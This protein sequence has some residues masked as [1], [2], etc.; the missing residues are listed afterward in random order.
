[1][2]R[3]L[4]LLFTLCIAASVNAQSDD[5]EIKT[6]INSFFDGMRKGDS[7][8]VRKAFIADPFLMTS[9]M[10]KGE[11]HFE[12]EKLSQLLKAVSTPRKPGEVYDERLLSMEI[13]VDDRLASVWTP[14]A[15]YV[16]ETF[17]H[18]GVNSFHMYKGKDGWRIAGIFDT[19]RREECPR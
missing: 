8:L 6:V 11:P 9:Y 14:Y 3:L 5:D 18:C 13:K 4:V 2:K 10:R 7:V 16:G 1:M 12:T 17:S 15:F 19:R